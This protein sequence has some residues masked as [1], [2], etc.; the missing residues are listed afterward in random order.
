MR[1]LRGSFARLVHQHTDMVALHFPPG[2]RIVSPTGGFLLWVELPAAYDV[3]RRWSDI[4]NVG[5]SLAAGP[6]F[7]AGGAFRSALRINAGV[8]W[9]SATS[10]AYESL[11][12]FL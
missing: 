3:T 1:R 9:T 10:R 6:M 12:Q 8:E 7:S 5:L 4:S 11:R 2:A